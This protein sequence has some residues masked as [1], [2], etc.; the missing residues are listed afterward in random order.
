MKPLSQKKGITA[1]S[2][3]SFLFVFVLETGSVYVILE[4]LELRQTQAGLEFTEILYPLSLVAWFKDMC[5]N[6]QQ[7]GFLF[8]ELNFLV[9]VMSRSQSTICRSQFLPSTKQSW[10]SNSSQAWQHAPTELLYWL[11]MCKFL[12]EHMLLVFFSIQPGLGHLVT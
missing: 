9:C 10:K 4:L 11:I 2:C 12:S 5:P 8:F 3:T 7:V 1:L 6:A